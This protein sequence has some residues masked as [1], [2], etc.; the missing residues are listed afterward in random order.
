ML[1]FGISIFNCNNNSS[2]LTVLI[3]HQ[4]PTQSPL[5]LTHLLYHAKSFIFLLIEALVLRCKPSFHKSSYTALVFEFVVA[6]TVRQR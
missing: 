4:F 2:C 1:R 6:R 5:H 3:A